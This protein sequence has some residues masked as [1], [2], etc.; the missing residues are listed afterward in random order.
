[1]VRSSVEN[2]GHDAKFG[3][4]FI[5]NDKRFNVATS[6]A[7]SLLIVVGNPKL[8]QKDETWKRFINYCLNNQAVVG[9]SF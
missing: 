5:F 6:R 3:L 2:L 7:K 9:D 1:M 4:G 8:L